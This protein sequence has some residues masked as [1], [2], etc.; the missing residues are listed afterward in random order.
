MSITAPVTVENTLVLRLSADDFGTDSSPAGDARQFVAVLPQP[1]LG[2]A[3]SVVLD[4]VDENAFDRIAVGYQ[5]DGQTFERTWTKTNDLGSTV[6]YTLLN[7][8]TDD[9][10]VSAA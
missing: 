4:R 5:V 10:Y 1:G 7:S 6:T 3:T 8:A 9:N 2:S